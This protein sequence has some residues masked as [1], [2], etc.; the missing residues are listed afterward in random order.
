[1]KKRIILDLD[2]GFDDTVCLWLAMMHKSIKVEGITLVHG[3]TTMTNVKKNV[4][5]ALDMIK[6]NGN[7]KV[8]EGE[9][10]PLSSYGVNTDDFAHGSNGFS[11]LIYEEIPGII[12]KQNAVDFLIEHVNNNPN[13][14]SIVAVSPLT[15]IAKAIQKNK[16]FAK[17]VKEII[18]MG[19][20][21]NYGNITEYAEFNFYKDPDAAHIVFNSG[22]KNIVMIGFNATKK[23]TFDFK[24]EA[25]LNTP[26]NPKGKFLY[27]ISRSCAQ[28]NIEYDETDGAIIND[29]LNI[30]YLINPK[31]I[32]TK[33]AK[34]EI[35]LKDQERLG[36]SKIYH[37][38]PNCLVATDIDAKKCKYLV[39]STIFP[40]LTSLLKE[41]I[42]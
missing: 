3:N 18:I 19:G 22:I 29:A 26:F 37:D 9:S 16:D 15:N 32:N 31:L 33:K 38:T 25:L 42:Q 12:E 30:C 2:M 13:K 8:Y 24:L 11:G 23:L 34:V 14:I 36:E 17:N 39:F 21:E 41:L 28:M 35:E 4:F 20:A 7:V 10:S 40:E 27:D 6:Q 5:K 1:M